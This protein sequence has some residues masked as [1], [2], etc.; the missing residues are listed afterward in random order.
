M[1]QQQQALE[2]LHQILARPEFQPPEQNPIAAFFG[3]IGK[4]V[5]DLFSSMWQVLRDG[6]RGEEGPIELIIVAVALLALAVIVVFVARAVRQSLSSDAT[7]AANQRQQRRERSDELWRQAQQAAVT[8]EYARATRLLY[9]SALY[10]LDEHAVLRVQVALT[11]REHASRLASDHPEMGPMF[12]DLVRQYD[13]L[14]YGG[15][16]ADADAFQRLNSLAAQA[17][18]GL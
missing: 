14:R 13:Q 12:A 15:L 1:D 9:L 6:A 10:A 7:V 2:Q 5:L 18:T 8:G 3:F 11:N 4:I 16:R 17:R